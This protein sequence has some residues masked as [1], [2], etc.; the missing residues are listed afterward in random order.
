MIFWA[1]LTLCIILGF[2]RI[3]KIRNLKDY[4]VGSTQFSTMM[5][6]LSMIA[7]LVDAHDTLGTTEKAF[8]MGVMFAGTAFLQIFRWKFMGSILAPALGYLRANNCTTLVD[9]MKFLYGKWGRYV[10]VVCLSLGCALLAVFY[11]AAAFVLEMYLN[12]PF[13]YGAIAIAVAVSLYSIFGG[14][15]A[16]VVTD[17]VQFFIFIIIIPAIFVIGLQNIDLPATIAQIPYENTHI[18]ASSILLFASLIIHDLIPVTGYPFIQRA[19]MSSSSK[20]LRTVFN[21]TGTFDAGFMLMMGVI[22]LLVSGMNPHVKSDHAMFYF[23]DNAVPASISGFFA[24]SMMAI[25]MSTASS[26]LNAVTVVVI[27]DIVTPAFPSLGSDRKQLLLTKFGGVVV[28]IAS[29][30]IMFVKDHIVDILW[31][32]D[33][34]WDPFVS[35]PLILGLLGIRV[36]AKD[37]KYVVFGSLGAVLIARAIHGD[38]DTITLC[39]GVFTSAAMIF[40]LRDKSIQRSD[41]AID[42]SES[43]LQQTFAIS[44]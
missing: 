38:F 10:C 19:L 36:K 2:F 12:V 1:Y 42:E 32:L 20:Q 24:I 34:F 28:A 23:V 31:M 40:A 6:A 44:K 9:I 17:V 5:L 29:F 16:I 21:I 41:R 39:A 22:G 26:F 11:K 15:H 37:F 7:T 35:I 27:K 4:T 30:G 43:E 13:I 33:N 8:S 18:G 14:I 25:I 3:P